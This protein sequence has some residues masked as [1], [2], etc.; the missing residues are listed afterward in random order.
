ME[1]TMAA[2]IWETLVVTI[3][4]GKGSGFPCTASGSGIKSAFGVAYMGILFG[5]YSIL[6]FFLRSL[7]VTFC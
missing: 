7:S 3:P 1:L 5:P 4:C 2:Y 6:G